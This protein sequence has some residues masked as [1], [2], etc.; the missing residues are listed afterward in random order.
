MVH[1]VW[2]KT[3]DY[4]LEVLLGFHSKLVNSVQN[5]PVGIFQSNNGKYTC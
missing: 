5:H 1:E 3:D 4:L 2:L